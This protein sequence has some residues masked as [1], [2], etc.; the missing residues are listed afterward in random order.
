MRKVLGKLENSPHER[1]SIMQT[2]G[3]PKIPHCTPNTAVSHSF[4][5]DTSCG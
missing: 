1:N 2:A 5:A 4:T 3:N